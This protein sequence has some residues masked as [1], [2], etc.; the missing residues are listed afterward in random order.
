MSRASESMRRLLFIAALIVMDSVKAQTLSQP[1]QCSR[2]SQRNQVCVG[3]RPDSNVCGQAAPLFGF[4][5]PPYVCNDVLVQKT[6]PD[7]RIIY[8]RVLGGD[9]EDLPRQFFLDAGD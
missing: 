2:D 8:S 6:A 4:R 3:T 1:G 9:S 7:G 5:P